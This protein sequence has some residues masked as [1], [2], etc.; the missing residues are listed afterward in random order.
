MH[1]TVQTDRTLIRQRGRSVRYALLEFTAP[2]PSRQASRP[3]L[4]VSFVI[5]RSGS[6][7]GSKIELA[8]TAVIQALRMLRETDRFSVI[9]YDDQV[10]VVVPSTRATAEAVRNAVQQVTRITARGSTNLG[11]GWLKGCEAVAEHLADDQAARCLLLSDGL[12]NHGITDPQELAE[13]SSVLGR[14]GIRTSCFGIGEDYDER[15]LDGIATASNGHAYNVETA[16][17]ILD[18]LAS[19]LGEAL[20]I[21]VR[22]AVVTVR[23]SAGITVRTLNSY[24]LATN[25]DGSVSMRL[26]DLTARQ[27]VS[28]V[29]ELTLPE[30]RETETRGAVFSVADAAGAQQAPP[31]DIVWTFAGEAENDAQPR[32]R[33]VDR[34]VAQLYAA[35]AQAEALELNRA[36][37]YEEARAGLVGAA[38][39]IERDAGSDPELRVMIEQMREREATYVQPMSSLHRKR[40]YA[41]SYNVSRMRDPE[42]KARRRPNR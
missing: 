15:L 9:S 41:S 12:A 4:N 2:E 20:G 32:N 28:A 33:A 23:P 36:G 11:G 5:D 18:F 3:P 40:E 6:M 19:E 13:H 42:G 10:D 29:F 39:R 17:Q 14:R 30:G 38:L 37:R 26:G 22:D 24:P 25:A 31:A 21:V 7:G 1:I 34:A 16:I 8:R 27:D 35:A